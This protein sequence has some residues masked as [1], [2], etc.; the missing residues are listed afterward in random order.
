MGFDLNLRKA[1]YDA[2]ALKVLPDWVVELDVWSMTRGDPFPPAV[3][4]D[5]ALVSAQTA[6]AREVLDDGACRTG[7]TKRAMARSV[8]SQSGVGV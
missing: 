3:H 6:I 4:K 8:H 1:L 5:L 7:R 2:V